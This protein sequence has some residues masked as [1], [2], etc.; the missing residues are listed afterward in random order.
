[1]ST[2]NI[3]WSYAVV[4]LTVYHQCTAAN[5]RREWI[6]V[7]NPHST[8]LWTNN[9]HDELYW[10]QVRGRVSGSKVN[11]I[12]LPS[13]HVQLI[14]SSGCFLSSVKQ[15]VKLKEKSWFLSFLVSFLAP[16]LPTRSVDR[17]QILTHVRWLLEFIK[18]GQ[19]F[20]DP[21][22]SKFGSNYRQFCNLIANISGTQQ[23]IVER[24]TALET[25]ITPARALII[26]WTLVF[27]WQKLWLEFWP[28]QRAAIRLSFATH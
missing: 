10:G 1:M 19:K 13:F 8:H 27:K 6:S 7:C 12:T 14:L 11:V 16:N 25:S 23:D 2:V 5:V 17:H 15:S 24:K 20:V 21:K 9:G 18:L 28:T 22:A 4:I 3:S 26:W